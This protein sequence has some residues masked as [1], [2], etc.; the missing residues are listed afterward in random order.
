MRPHAQN[1]YD[2]VEDDPISFYNTFDDAVD[3]S[4]LSVDASRIASC[5]IAQKSFV[6]GRGAAR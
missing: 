5:Q 6:R 3:E 1:F 2:A 4:V